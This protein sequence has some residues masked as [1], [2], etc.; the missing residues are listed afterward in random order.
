MRWICGL[1]LVGAALL[2]A[3]ELVLNP[4]VAV[5]ALGPHL[6]PLEIGL[7]LGLGFLILSGLYWRSLRWLAAALFT[8]FAGY[9]LYL[10]INGA[11]SCNCF[12]PLKVNP[13]WTFALDSIVV[14]GFLISIRAEGS[15]GMAEPNRNEVLSTTNVGRQMAVAIMSI[16]LIATL[17]LFRLADRRTVSAEGGATSG[18]LLILEPDK[19]VAQSLPI[20]ESIDLDLKVGDWTVLLHRHDCPLCQAVIPQF[21]NRAKNGERIVLVEVPPYGDF[22]PRTEACTY[23]RLKDDHEWFVQTPVEI[24]LHDGVVT[25]VHTFDH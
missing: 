3:A 18:G 5:H 19:W 2:K 24:R 12:G 7:E 9:A 11:D 8:A 17:L 25:A 14:V 22:E 15:R 20:A 6:L 4:T 16:T 13:W 23:R 1:L 10:A 21:E